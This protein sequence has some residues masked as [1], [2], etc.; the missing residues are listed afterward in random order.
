MGK[1]VGPLKTAWPLDKVVSLLAGVVVLLTL[2]LGRRASP[3]WRLLTAFV[4]ANLMLN[5]TVGW[6]PTS[7]V[8]HRLGVQTR[9]EQHDAAARDDRR[10][11]SEMTA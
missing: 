10:E 2:G 5:G 6:C 3:R 7:L 11:P 8:L 9:C 1:N 4:G